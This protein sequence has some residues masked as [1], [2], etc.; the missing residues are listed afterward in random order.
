VRV[1]IVELTYPFL[2]LALLA[3]YLNTS[4]KRYTCL[5]Y[6]LGLSLE[7]AVSLLYE[8]FG[9]LES[10]A[11]N[12]YLGIVLIDLSI[13]VLMSYCYHK[14]FFLVY[15]LILITI[16]IGGILS[17]ERLLLGSDFVLNNSRSWLVSINVVI[18]LI[19]FGGS[20]SVQRIMG[21]LWIRYLQVSIQSAGHLL[22]IH[23]SQD[24]IQ[25][26]ESTEEVKE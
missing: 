3:A 7:L 5:L 15:L 1:D 2:T 9:L 11:Y 12:Y 10:H 18:L 17:I 22:R 24:A 19:F 6:G 8:E 23:P 21:R 26:T 20:S 16:T 4:N 13:L 14:D 25:K